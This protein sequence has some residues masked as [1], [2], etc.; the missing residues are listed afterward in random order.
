M[1]FTKPGSSGQLFGVS[2]MPVMINCDTWFKSTEINAIQVICVHSASI[3]DS[4]PSCL[5][6]CDPSLRNMSGY[7]A[8][9]M[10]H[11]LYRKSSPSA[12]C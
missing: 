12:A 7:L 2:Y 4:E 6:W 5:S 11:W 8:I 10:H 3:N 9:N 1:T